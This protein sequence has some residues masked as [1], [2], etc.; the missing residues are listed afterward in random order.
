MGKVYGMLPVEVHLG[1]DPE[2][3][4]RFARHN[5]QQ[6]PRLEGWRFTLLKADRSSQ[7]DQVGRYQILIEIESR[8]ARDRV[9]PGTGSTPLLEQWFAEATPVLEQWRQYTTTAPGLEGTFTDYH[10]IGA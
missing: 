5:L 3:F 7:E 2:E 1:I 4:E 6:L 10:D 9:N 8:E